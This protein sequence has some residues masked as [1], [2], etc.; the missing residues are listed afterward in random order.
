MKKMSPKPS[1]HQDGSDT[2]TYIYVDNLNSAQ[3]KAISQVPSV[4]NIETIGHDD[5]QSYHRRSRSTQRGATDHN[6]QK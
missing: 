4:Q 2:E 3:H 6:F 1:Q 5:G